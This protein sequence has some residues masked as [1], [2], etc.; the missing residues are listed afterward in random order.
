MLTGTILPILVAVF[1]WWFAT[2][3]ILWLGQRP[4]KT[5]ALSFALATIVA[6][7]AAAGLA[8]SAKTMTAG[9]VY[10]AFLCALALW[11]WI[12]ISF[13]M[14][15]LTGPRTAP[16]PPEA[17]GWRRF[18]LAA[19]TLLWHEGAIVLLAALIVALT[20]G[21]PNQTGTLAFLILAAMRL[22][23]K[24]NLFFG[25]PY[26][27]QEF[28]PPRLAY[29]GSYFG[30]RSVNAI[31][32]YTIV[33]A[34]MGAVAIAAKA[35][36]ADTGAAEAICFALLFGLIA[37]AIL[38]HLFMVLPFQEAALWRWAMPGASVPK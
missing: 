3:A 9:S 37:L 31:W 36:G 29:L 23:A 30:R 32:P 20:W 26:I 4:A 6:V 38:E 2:G 15:F 35:L 8:E 12:E 7:L 10:A 1:V 5:Y 22:S 14:G 33:I 25:V 13:L 11:G 16:C 24:L 34:A 17:T 18:N 19:Q 21:A 28:L 27:T